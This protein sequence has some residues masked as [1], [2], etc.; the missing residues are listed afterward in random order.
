MF[1]QRTHAIAPIH[2][3]GDLGLGKVYN[4]RERRNT[5]EIWF[6]RQAGKLY[7]YT[8]EQFTEEWDWHAGAPAADA[9]PT[10]GNYRESMNTW[11]MGWVCTLE[12]DRHLPL[13]ANPG[14]VTRQCMP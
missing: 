12:S 13:K 10:A 11:Q 6:A 8:P 2:K 1:G 9:A 14:P 7:H 4:T 5:E 3:I